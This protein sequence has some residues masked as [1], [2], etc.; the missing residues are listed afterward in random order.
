MTE[1][2]HRWMI[3]GAYGYSGELIAREAARLGLEPVLAGRNA[4]K[5][6]PLGEALGLDI[7]VLDL[8]D[9]AELAMA[10]QPMHL[11]LHCAGPFS[12]TAGPMMD[13]CIASQTHYLDITGEI[14]VFEAG[15]RR[16][17]QA[18]A[19]GVAL[20]PGVGFD[21]IPTDCVAAHLKEA[22][23][24]AT[25]LALGFDSRSGMSPGTAKSSIEGMAAGGRVRQG[26]VIKPVPLA[27][28]VREIDFGNGSKMAMTIPWGDVSTAFHSTGIPDIEVYVPASPRLIK[29]ARRANWVRPLM[30]FG[31]VQSLLKTLAGRRVTGPDAG[32][33]DKLITHV[34][35]EVTDDRGD[36]RVARI[37]TGNGYNV[38][39]DGSLMVAQHLL[40][41]TVE[42][43]YH[44]PS[45]LVDKDLV[46]RLPGSG[47]LT[48]GEG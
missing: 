30:G 40:T 32:K 22:L 21:V 33:R 18:R 7:A 11:V 35:G 10:L 36:R 12:A 3:Y 42:G 14:E 27:A 15:A 34:W 41:Q 44:T 38:T 23:P 6:E 13:A 5:L 31:P 8:H 46:K 39:R 28:S 37:V 1:Q 48:I 25:R 20:C 17:A 26:G 24:G 29:Q 47:E 43:G 9:E 2:T 45:T 16:D 4:S 19:A